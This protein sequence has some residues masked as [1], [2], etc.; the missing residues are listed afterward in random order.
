MKG[1]LVLV[2]GNYMFLFVI[3]SF[4]VAFAKK[5]WLLKGLLPVFSWVLVCKWLIINGIHFSCLHAFVGITEGFSE[6]GR[7][8][9]QRDSRRGCMPAPLPFVTCVLR[10]NVLI[11]NGIHFCSSRR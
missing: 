8:R 10:Y 6:R 9:E 3:S 5:L 11:I 7:E 2:A 4:A 1:V